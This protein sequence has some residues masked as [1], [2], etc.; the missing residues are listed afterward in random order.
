MLEV[1]RKEIKYS[2]SFIDFYQAKPLLG[3]GL[4]L[5]PH[6]T[7]DDGYSVR[8]L[9][10]DSACDDDLFDVLSGLLNKQKIRLRCYDPDDAVFKLEHKCK[11]GTDSIKQSIPIPRSKAREL[12]QGRFHVLSALPGDTA[13]ELYARMKMGVYQPRVVVNYQRIAYFSPLND[14][15]VT[16]DYDVR[17]SFSPSAL[18]D[19]YAAFEPVM[20]P[21]TGVL[22]VKY[23]NFLPSYLMTILGG[24]N[25]L[26]VS[27]SK[28]VQ[29]RLLLQ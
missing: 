29:A 14:I 22:E 4:T 3:A 27:N 19:N 17:A 25:A 10:F 20:E 6:C 1:F 2:A 21:C 18:F 8:S 28:Y 15:R 9:Y 23:N 5:D 7:N 11:T 16:F 26:A 24:F 12:A 13:K